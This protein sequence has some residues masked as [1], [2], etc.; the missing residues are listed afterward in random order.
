MT[1]PKQPTGAEPIRDGH[2]LN[3]ELESAGIYLTVNC[4]HDGTDWTTYDLMDR[5]RC[6]R[7]VDPHDGTPDNDHANTCMISEWS[8][9]V[10]GAAELLDLGTGGFTATALPIEVIYWWTVGDQLYLRPVA[11]PPGE[12][13]YKTLIT[14][15]AARS[16][17]PERAA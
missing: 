1:A 8:E 10:T 15:V 6:R 13:E 3:V 4:P 11:G 16:A 9:A 2:S 17:T 14:E 7:V 12:T 5:P